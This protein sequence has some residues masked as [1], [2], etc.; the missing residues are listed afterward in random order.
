MSF[1]RMARDIADSMDTGAVTEDP[2]SQKPEH[3]LEVI[4]E[5]MGLLHGITRYRTVPEDASLAEKA[6]FNKIS[7]AV[8]T[9]YN[10]TEGIRLD[11]DEWI[12]DYD[13]ARKV[14]ESE[15]SE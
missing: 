12:I 10:Q 2:A 8:K 3:V 1:I 4:E 14:E 5:V 13:A 15:E 9:M 7:Q 6:A 11:L